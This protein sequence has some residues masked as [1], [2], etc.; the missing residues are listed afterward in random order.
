MVV[1]RRK[2]RVLLW[3]LV[4][5]K[6]CPVLLFLN[7]G[8][9]DPFSTFFYD[10][11]HPTSLLVLEPKSRVFSVVLAWRRFFP[12]F[13]F[14]SFL[15]FLCLKEEERTKKKGEYF[16]CLSP[17]SVFVWL[18]CAVLLLLTFVVFARCGGFPPSGTRFWVG[19]SHQP[20]TSAHD[21]TKSQCPE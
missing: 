15:C 1:L 8:N 17:C 14:A 9:T 4:R 10:T 20:L 21:P 7:F 12:F 2:S 19:R 11:N 16:W 6:S 13:L 5:P 3:C 18:V